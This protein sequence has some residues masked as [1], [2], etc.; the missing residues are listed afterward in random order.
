MER[1][2]SCLLLIRLIFENILSLNQRCTN[3][4]CYKNVGLVLLSGSFEELLFFSNNKYKGHV[5]DGFPL[6]RALLVIE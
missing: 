4:L 5:I 1:C 3:K 6:F 2:W